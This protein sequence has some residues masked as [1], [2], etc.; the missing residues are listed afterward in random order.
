MEAPLAESDQV[1][2]L[3]KMVRVLRT[4]SSSRTIL[5]VQSDLSAMG[6]FSR[7]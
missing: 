1:V 2:M 6:A 3:R 7:A 4:E 5:M